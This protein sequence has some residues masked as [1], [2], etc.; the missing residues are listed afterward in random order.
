MED[1]QYKASETISRDAHVQTLVVQCIRVII[2]ERVCIRLP[3]CQEE[4]RSNSLPPKIPE[5]LR[6]RIVRFEIDY[7]CGQHNKTS[8]HMQRFRKRDFYDVH[9][10]LSTG[11]EMALNYVKGRMTFEQVLPVYLRYKGDVVNTL[12]VITTP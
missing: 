3:L 9:Q 4:H 2:D 12:L 1:R 7:L 10:T 8:A 5:E 11:I 6:R